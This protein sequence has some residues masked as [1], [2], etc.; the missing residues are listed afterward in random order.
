[1]RIITLI[2]EKHLH[3]ELIKVKSHS[4]IELN[5]RVDQIAKEGAEIGYDISTFFTYNSNHVRYFSH[6]Q[7][8]PIEHKFRRFVSSAFQIKAEAEWALLSRIE[9]R[10]E[11]HS[12]WWKSSWA[13]FT[14]ITGFRCN[15]S[16]KHRLWSYG[17]KAF[18]RLLPLGSLLT[19]R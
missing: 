18:H 10:L 15:R 5:E 13:F 4:G 6:F 8:I 9:E 3:L 17:V 11:N 19:Q 16:V 14:N 12:L 2:R 7:N 1:M